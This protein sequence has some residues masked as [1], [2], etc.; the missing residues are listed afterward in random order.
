MSLRARLAALERNAARA[1]SPM[2]ASLDRDRFLTLVAEAKRRIYEGDV[3]QLQLGIRFGAELEGSGF[4]FYRA[5]RRVNPSPYMFLLEL[6]GFSLVGASPEIHVRCEDGKV[7]LRPIAGT[8]RGPPR[9]RGPLARGCRGFCG[10][11]RWTI[12]I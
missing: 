5:L 9:C 10:P 4:D 3:Y 6:E 8:R 12:R 11:S 2:S 7:E 1:G